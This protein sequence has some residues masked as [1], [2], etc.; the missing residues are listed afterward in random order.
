MKEDIKFAAVFFSIILFATF[1]L[2]FGISKIVTKLNADL[3][4]Q[5]V[6]IL[7]NHDIELTDDII[8]MLIKGE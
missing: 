7:R 3:F 1:C 8:Y 6:E 4:E 5:K 2:V